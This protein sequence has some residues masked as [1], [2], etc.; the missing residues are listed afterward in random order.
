MLKALLILNSEIRYGCGGA[1][2]AGGA[3]KWR[4]GAQLL[5]IVPVTAPSEASSIRAKNLFFM[6][7]MFLCYNTLKS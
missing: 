2:G 4:G 3:C 5:N 1:G 7:L 6:A